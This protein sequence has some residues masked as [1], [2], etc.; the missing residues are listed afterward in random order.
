MREESLLNVK[1]WGLVSVGVIRVEKFCVFYF[2]RV[3][4]FFRYSKILEREG[5]FVIFRLVRL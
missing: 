5:L 3:F 4:F 2:G 1:E